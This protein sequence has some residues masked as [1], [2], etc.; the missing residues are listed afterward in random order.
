MPDGRPGSRSLQA[1][2]PMSHLQ[3]ATQRQANY[4]LVRVVATFLVVQLHVATPWLWRSNDMSDPLWITCLLFDS[5]GRMGVPIFLML[6]GSLLLPRE[7][8][9]GVF[10]RKRFTRILIPLAFWTLVFEIYLAGAM[11]I[12]KGVRDW[13]EI[14]QGLVNPIVK[15]ASPHLWYLYMILGMYLVTPLLRRVLKHLQP[16][17]L[18]FALGLWFL[19]NCIS[20]LIRRHFEMRVNIDLPILTPYLAFF[21]LGYYADRAEYSA[22]QIRLAWAG[23]ASAWL[24]SV[25]LT[26]IDSYI[27]GKAEIFYLAHHSPF[28]FI[29]AVCGFILFTHYG[30]KL[31]LTISPRASQLL[32]LGGTLTYGIYLVHPL[33][34]ELLESSKLG[35]TLWAP[36]F[37]PPIGIPLTT[38]VVFLLSGA[39]VWLIDQVPGLRKVV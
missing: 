22:K 11:Y 14:W 38:L 39:T 34:I 9:Y 3:S 16:P 10:F 32:T 23:L 7:D 18:R 27:A 19:F 33:F 30:R 21:V 24:I 26:W 20:P 31:T 15:P 6:S 17:D 36:T 4:D 37:G 2:K 1:R 5:I 28:V 25:V 29:Q 8:S 12:D 35:F 13:G